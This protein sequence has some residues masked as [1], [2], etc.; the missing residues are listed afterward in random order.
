MMKNGNLFTVKISNIELQVTLAPLL[1]LCASTA[2]FGS[3]LGSD[4]SGYPVDD[5]GK[6]GF[7][8]MFL[9]DLIL[10][11]KTIKIDMAGIVVSRC[12]GLIK[13]T[14]RFDEFEF[15]YIE[16]EDME[17][18]SI[19]IAKEPACKKNTTGKLIVRRPFVEFPPYYGIY[20]VLRI[21]MKD[22]TWNQFPPEALLEK[23]QTAART[24]R[25]NRMNYYL[26]HITILS[27]YVTISLFTLFS[28]H[29]FYLNAAMIF[30]LIFL[31]MLFLPGKLNSL[32]EEYFLLCLKRL[33]T[34][35]DA[36]RKRSKS[37]SD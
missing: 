23:N 10:L 37:P 12:F 16:C 8:A 5:F 34:I 32:E 27:C 9:I 18:L 21:F 11:N 35:E 30:G 13:K 22:L 33:E 28:E 24:I 14:Y 26:V 4:L 29:F 2:Q 17:A 7:F 3:W 15:G 31:Y 36:E 25:E 6:C 19:Y 20:Q 1:F